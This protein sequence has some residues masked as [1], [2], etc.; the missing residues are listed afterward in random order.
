MQWSVLVMPSRLRSD[1]RGDRRLNAQQR[2]RMKRIKQRQRESAERRMNQADTLFL[3][4]H[5]SGPKDICVMSFAQGQ[6]FHDVSIGHRCTATSH[7][8]L[9]RKHV[10]I[11]VERGE[12]Q[13][14]GDHCKIASWVHHRTWQAAPSGPVTVMQLLPGLGR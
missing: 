3:T 14:R 8:H 1:A 11:L 7:R 9:S 2:R 4:K 10:D 5:T 6:K 13:W 12:L